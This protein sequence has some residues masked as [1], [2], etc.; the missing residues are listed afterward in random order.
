MQTST[1]V[2]H[3]QPSLRRPVAITLRAL[4]L[5][6]LFLCALLPAPRPRANAGQASL[7]NLQGAAASEYL[8]QQGLQASPGKAMARSGVYPPPVSDQPSYRFY[9]NTKRSRHR[10]TLHAA[11]STKQF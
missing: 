5:L 2:P 9:A 11:S 6:T 1:S 7:P 4:L 10:H 8:K 3:A